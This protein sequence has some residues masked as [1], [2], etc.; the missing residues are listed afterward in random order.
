MRLDSFLTGLVVGVMLVGIL[1]EP[2]RKN[3]I[4]NEDFMKQLEEEFPGEDWDNLPDIETLPDVF[5]VHGY[6]MVDSPPSGKFQ[7]KFGKQ[8]TGFT[9]H[10][11]YPTRQE[12]EAQVE[13]CKTWEGV[14]PESIEIRVN[15]PEAEVWKRFCKD[16]REAIG[17][18]EKV[19]PMYL[20]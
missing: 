2:K 16:C 8:Q 13:R 6:Q 17:R 18:G 20:P 11:E 14:I 12:A 10:K 9:V 1:A 5:T 15:K 7:G 3:V 4:S 19:F